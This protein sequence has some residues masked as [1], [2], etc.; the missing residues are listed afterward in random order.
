L[1]YRSGTGV[2]KDVVEAYKWFKLAAAKDSVSGNVY[3][4]DLARNLPREDVTEGE[5]RAA[6]FKPGRRY[7]VGNLLLERVR[8]QAIAGSGSERVALIND[9][10]V[11]VGEEVIISIM[12]ESLQL[13][14]IAIGDGAVTIATT[15]G[16]QRKLSLA[17]N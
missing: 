17:G 5:R 9:Q 2:P 15:D 14:C 3:L 10:I 7:E 8:L 12:G 6:E 1:R 16:R 13:K 4:P 11:R